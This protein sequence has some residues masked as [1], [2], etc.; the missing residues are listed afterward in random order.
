MSLC[1]PQEVQQAQVQSPA[2]GS[3]QPPASIQPGTR[4][5]LGQTCIERLGDTS[6]LKM[7]YELAMCTFNP[8]S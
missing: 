7:E 2:S 6:G 8:E 4:T 3:Q 5:D 1:K